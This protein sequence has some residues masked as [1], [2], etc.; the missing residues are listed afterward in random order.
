[1]SSKMPPKLPSNIRTESDLDAALAALGKAEPRF[2]GLVE[3][4]GR[5]SLRRRPEGFAG[6]ARAVVA[7]N[8]GP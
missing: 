3:V 1:M 7:E 6:L 2:A 5:P 4:A 8:P